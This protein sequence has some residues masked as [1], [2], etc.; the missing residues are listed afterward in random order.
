MSMRLDKTGHQECARSIGESLRRSAFDTHDH[1]A[2]DREQKGAAVEKRLA[3]EIRVREDAP[4][5]H[6]S[7][8]S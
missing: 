4:D 1:A 2:V 3:V 8:T 5:G 6:C 7:I